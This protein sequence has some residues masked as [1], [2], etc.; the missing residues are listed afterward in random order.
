MWDPVL[1]FLV[2]R[3]CSWCLWSLDGFGDP[4]CVCLSAPSP[5]LPASPT[6]VTTLC[7][8]PLSRVADP[9]SPHVGVVPWPLL[10]S[11]VPE[12]GWCMGSLVRV[13]GV[14]AASMWR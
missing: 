9:A 10:A 13:G 4:C 14:G 2:A 3:P 11:G 7:S 1:V 12:V 5:L 8:L 6:C